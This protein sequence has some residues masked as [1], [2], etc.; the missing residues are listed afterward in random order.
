MTKILSLY[1]NCSKGGMTTVYRTRALASPEDKHDFIFM[2]DRGGREAFNSLPNTDYRIF[3]KGRFT[4]AIKYIAQNFDY[5]QIRVTSMP[6]AANQLSQALPGK[7]TYE[8][9]S[10][11]V[12]IIESELSRLDIDALQ[13]IQTPSN[14]LT[15]VVSRRLTRSQAEKCVTVPNLVDQGTFNRSVPPTDRLLPEGTVPILWIGRFDKGKN[16]NDFLRVLS[17]LPQSFIP[18]VVVSYETE[19]DRISRALQEARSYGV[20]DRILTHLNLSQNQLAGLYTW[21]RDH[22]GLFVSTSLAES[23]G[24]SIAE[25]LA[26]GLP[27]V[28]YR[29]GGVPEVPTFGTR[30]QLVPVGNVYQMAAAV[31]SLRLGSQTSA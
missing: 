9:H 20:A 8:F 14:W 21:T 25:A 19:P 24:Y 3:V 16:F 4:P 6:E 26:C 15:N 23:F 12:A 29:V 27:T 30:H 18:I 2:N 11:T 17:I 10:S 5:D 22:G 28:A 7:V 31:E 1:P 13:S